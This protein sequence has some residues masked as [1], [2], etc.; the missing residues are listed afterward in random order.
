MDIEFYPVVQE[1]K[2]KTI[3]KYHH[4][5]ICQISFSKIKICFHEES[6]KASA[7]ALM[8]S[9]IERGLP[10]WFRRK[11]LPANAGHTGL[12]PGSERSPELGNGNPLQYSCL[13]NSTDRGAWNL[14]SLGSQKRWRDSVTKQPHDREDSNNEISSHE[15]EALAKDP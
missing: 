11:I 10:W 13:E 15:C 1:C 14:Q 6:R 4:Q 12:I 5:E 7:A 8:T 9:L 3:F 2:K